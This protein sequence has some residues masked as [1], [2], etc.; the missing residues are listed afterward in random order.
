M[1]RKMMELFF[2]ARTLETKISSKLTS[3]PRSGHM[4]CL[5]RWFSQV[6]PE[7]SGGKSSV[8]LSEN[9]A[10]ICNYYPKSQYSVSSCSS[11]WA[12]PVTNWHIGIPLIFGQ[13]HVFK[14][15]FNQA[16]F[17]CLTDCHLLWAILSNDRSLAI[18]FV[19]SK[20]TTSFV[21][22]S[23]NSAYMWQKMRASRQVLWDLSSLKTGAGVMEE[24]DMG[25]SDD[26]IFCGGS[27]KFVDP[28]NALYTRPTRIGTMM[29]CIV[30]WYFRVHVAFSKDL[31]L[32]WICIWNITS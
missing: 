26:Q 17:L 20:L 25:W 8:A 5:V 24:K 15:I 4:W 16:D 11:L 27:S 1:H 32:H 7:S 29:C 19:P 10:I 13:A 21:Q 9:M 23:K 28:K 14:S 12:I 3:Q 31:H 2:K 22:I 6:V 30:F 18:F